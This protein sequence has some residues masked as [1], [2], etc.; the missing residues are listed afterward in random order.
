MLLHAERPLG[1]SLRILPC[2]SSIQACIKSVGNHAK[3]FGLRKQGK[4]P[5]SSALFLVLCLN[6]IF[7]LYFFLN[8][9]NHNK[10]LVCH[11]HINSFVNLVKQLKSKINF[12]FNK[13]QNPS[14][15]STNGTL[16]PMLGTLPQLKV[17]ITC[18]NKQ[19]HKRKKKQ[20]QIQT[21]CQLQMHATLHMQGKH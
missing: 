3:K 17:K 6:F 12:Y 21:N 18:K 5:V 9:I 4:I 15:K 2:N 8:E 20:I 19:K 13:N 14:G 1:I 7:I 10:N 16:S 11:A